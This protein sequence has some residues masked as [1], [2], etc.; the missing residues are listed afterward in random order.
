MWTLCNFSLPDKALD[1]LNE[2]CGSILGV[3]IFSKNTHY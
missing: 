1:E 3:A 2:I